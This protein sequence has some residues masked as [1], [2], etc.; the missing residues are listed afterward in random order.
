MGAVR[1]FLFSLTAI[2]ALSCS[3]PEDG[4][5]RRSS[6]PL[7]RAKLLSPK[8]TDG[9]R[10]DYDWRFFDSAKRGSAGPPYESDAE[11]SRAAVAFLTERFGSLP[12]PLE[13]TRVLR[14]SEAAREPDGSGHTVSLHARHQGVKLEHSYA[15]VYIAGR[16]VWSATCSLC[17][18]EPIPDSEKPV[19]ARSKAVAIWKEGVARAFKVENPSPGAIELQYVWSPVDPQPREK[20]EGQILRPNW[21][22]QFPGSSDELLVDA[23]T[24]RLWRND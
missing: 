22:I 21:V 11:A 6:L 19:L 18:V 1:T 17:S 12:D 8:N 2:M 14:S 10:L 5:E 9:F 13:A 7:L 23:F 16:T 15:V 3:A 20:S 24:G 4:T